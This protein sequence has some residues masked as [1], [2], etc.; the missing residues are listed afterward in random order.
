MLTHLPSGSGSPGGRWAAVSK[1]AT[2]A[3]SGLMELLLM[4]DAEFLLMLDA[5]PIDMRE[6]RVGL[7]VSRQRE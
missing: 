1:S 5:C 3:A 7:S 6:P 2:I 4:L